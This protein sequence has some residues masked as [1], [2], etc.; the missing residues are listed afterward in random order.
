MGRTEVLGKLEALSTHYGLA[1]P[2][3]REHD[4]AKPKHNQSVTE[5]RM[6]YPVHWLVQ[7]ACSATMRAHLPCAFKINSTTSRTAP[8]PPSALVT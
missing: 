8:C 2:K 4:E 5:A 7:A 3:P 6:I 1:V